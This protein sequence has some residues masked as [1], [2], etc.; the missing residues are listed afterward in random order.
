MDFGLPERRKLSGGKLVVASNNAGKVR[1]IRALLEP[2]GFDVVSAGELDLPEPDETGLTYIANAELKARAAAQGS[3]FPALADDS[4][5]AVEALAGAPG[6][7]SAR[8]GGP[9][10]DF[11]LAMERVNTA[12]EARIAETGDDNRR[13][14]FICALSLGWPDGRCETFEGIVKGA[15]VWP[16]RGDEGFGY[17]PVFVADGETLTF[18]EM[19]QA[20][21][22][23]MSHRADAFQQLTAACLQP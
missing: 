11:A 12:L 8:A 6:I 4:G 21:K 15:L 14:R 2:R 5:L 10:R 22:H 13:A 18:G 7:Y 19:D 16:P 23:A 3:G 17:D 9:G 20:R 1:E